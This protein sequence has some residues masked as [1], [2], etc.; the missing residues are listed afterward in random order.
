M[1]YAASMRSRSFA[2]AS[3]YHSWSKEFLEAGASARLKA[4]VP[5]AHFAK[6]G[7]RYAN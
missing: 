6:A 3:L 5:S 2:G 7:H 4:I 1:G